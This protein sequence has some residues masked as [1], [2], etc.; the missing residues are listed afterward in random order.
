MEQVFKILALGGGS[1]VLYALVFLSALSIAVMIERA[2]YFLM[3]REDIVSLMDSVAG[4]LEKNNFEEAIGFV[5]DKKSPAKRVLFYGLSALD[6]GIPSVEELLSSHSLSERI[7]MERYLTI[8]GTIGN[9]APFIG[10]LGTVLGII[11]AFNDLSVLNTQGP[12]AVMAG[13]SDALV[14]TAAG[15][16]VAIPAVIAYNY[17]QRMVKTHFVNLESSS[18]II[19]SFLLR[20]NKTN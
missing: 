9:N 14:A 17:F 19:M 7:K 11:K 6:R 3:N 18:K 1:W 10:L 15:L 4:K 5:K 8:L 13:I 16:F 2:I 20:A 12:S